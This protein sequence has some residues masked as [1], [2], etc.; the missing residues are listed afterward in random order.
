MN[1]PYLILLFAAALLLVM[2]GWGL[3]SKS[4]QPPPAPVLP[5]TAPLVE[6]L[7]LERE[8]RMRERGELPDAANQPPST[9][10]AVPVD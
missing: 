10:P 6:R 5:A 3:Y 7:R 1:R 8:R 2:V 4:I 9:A